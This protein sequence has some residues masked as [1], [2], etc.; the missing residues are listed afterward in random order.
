V[1]ATTDEQRPAAVSIRSRQAGDTC[2]ERWDRVERTVWTQRMLEALETRVKE[3]VWFSL[4]DH[5][6]WPNKYFRDLGY[7]SRYDVHRSFL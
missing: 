5:M 6:R 7:F 4:I 1:K 3:A 2:S